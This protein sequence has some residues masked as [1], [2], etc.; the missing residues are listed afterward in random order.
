MAGSGVGCCATFFSS[1]D[2]GGVV[3]GVVPTLTCCTGTYCTT[4]FFSYLITATGLIS[5]YFGL[6]IGAF[7]NGCLG[8]TPSFNSS[9]II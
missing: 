9:S 6:I 8:N 1:W 5:G 7:T 2:V 3:V 4:S